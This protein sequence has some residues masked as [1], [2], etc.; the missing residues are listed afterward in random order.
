M[1]AALLAA[2]V[3]PT[4]AASQDVARGE[5]IYRLCTQC[6]GPDGAGQ[7]LALAPSIAGQPAWYVKAQLHNFKSGVRGVNPHDTGGLRMY[8]MSLSLKS[9]ADIDAVAAYVESMP[10]PKLEPTIVGD[11]SVGK[12]YYATCAACHGP[13]GAGK[14]EVKAPRLVGTSDWYLVESLKKFKAG[15][16]GGNPANQNSVLM[17]GMAMSLKDDQAIN[18]VVAYIHTLGK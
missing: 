1:I 7:A 16:R 8:P 12:T 17:R 9:D 11:A 4:V 18:D 13:D 6:H 3:I 14:Q 5:E 15:I 2:L 10:V